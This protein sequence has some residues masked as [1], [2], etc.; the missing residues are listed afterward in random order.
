[1]L[2]ALQGKIP[3]LTVPSDVFNKNYIAKTNF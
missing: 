1:M 2:D 3:D